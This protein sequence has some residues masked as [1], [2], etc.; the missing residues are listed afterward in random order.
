MDFRR[1]MA[2]KTRTEAA[3]TRSAILDAA[4]MEMQERGVSGAS[5]ERIARRANVTRGAIYWHFA[6]RDALLR[7]MVE[8]TDLPLR[9]LQYNLRREQPN[10]QPRTT[11]R[12]MLLHGLT[13]LATDS[14]HRRVCHIMMLGS[15]KIDKS[16]PV[17]NLL[18]TGFEDSRNVVNH[19][20]TEAENNGSLQ[21]HITP[22][23][24]SDVIMAF[25]CGVYNCSLRHGDLYPAKRDWAPIVDAL[26]NGLFVGSDTPEAAPVE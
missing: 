10:Q 12:E 7:A 19:L 16:D 22:N 18:H 15:E 14:H 23:Q 20:C 8:R 11:L 6:D 1:N 5:F 17:S 21:P 13:R 25:M 3:R 24:A 26:L 2:R 9:D 4:E